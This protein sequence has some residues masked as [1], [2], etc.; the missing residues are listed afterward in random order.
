MTVEADRN[1]KLTPI[2]VRPTAEMARDVQRLHELSNLPKADII[3]RACQFALPKF[4]SGEV[5]IVELKEMEPA[6]AQEV[7]A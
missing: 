3:R 7:G 6:T 4:L 2:P 1:E 5:S